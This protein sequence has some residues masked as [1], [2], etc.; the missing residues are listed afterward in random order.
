MRK[1]VPTLPSLLSSLYHHL[2]ATPSRTQQRVDIASLLAYNEQTATSTSR[3]EGAA[4]HL[5]KGAL[6]AQGCMDIDGEMILTGF[7]LVL[8]GFTLG[9]L[10]FFL[11]RHLVFPEEAYAPKNKPLS[12]KGD[13]LRTIGVLQQLQL[14]I[15]REAAE[16]DPSLADLVGLM[17]R[18][19]GEFGRR[20][21]LEGTIQALV[22][23]DME[24]QLA[25]RKRLSVETLAQ[26]QQET[27]IA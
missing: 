26:V 24:R 13:V 3:K 20:A 17:R 5:L 16:R 23:L 19:Q 10:V 9:M 21:S 18:A 2:I 25:R 11:V 15:G 12:Y 8:F 4:S 22:V 7:C 14:L 6:A 27:V 1:C